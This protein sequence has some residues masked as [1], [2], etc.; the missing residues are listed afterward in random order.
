MRHIQNKTELNRTI[1]I[2]LP[3]TH[4][5]RRW[6]IMATISSRNFW[7]LPHIFLWSTLPQKL[8][9]SWRVI[10]TCVCTYLC[11]D[12]ITAVEWGTV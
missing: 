6:E 3:G 7:T 9:S 1:M 10:P 2:Q 12:T 4:L 11:F 8:I 5:C